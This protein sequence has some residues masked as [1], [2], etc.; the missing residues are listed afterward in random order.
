MASEIMNLELIYL[1]L[2]LICL[3][4]EYK[5]NKIPP[6]RGH[7]YM[8]QVPV[9]VLKMFSIK[10]RHLNNANYWWVISR[11][12]IILYLQINKRTFNK[13]LNSSKYDGIVVLSKIVEVQSI[14]IFEIANQVYKLMLRFEKGKCS[15]KFT[16]SAF[17]LI[18]FFE[19]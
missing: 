6:V 4:L 13:L 10:V 3:L 17:I 2:M 16:L 12:R 7:G 5:C 11:N 8:S 14:I 15:W 9:F 19:F 18:T 1:W